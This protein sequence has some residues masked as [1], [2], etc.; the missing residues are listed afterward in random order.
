[1]WQL[2]RNLGTPNFWNPQSLSRPVMGFPYLY[3][4]PQPIACYTLYLRIHQ[5]IHVST[6][7]P[8]ATTLQFIRYIRVE[9]RHLVSIRSASKFCLLKGITQIKCAVIH[10]VADSGIIRLESTS[11]N[12]TWCCLRDC[13]QRQCLRCV[14]SVS[15]NGCPWCLPELLQTQ[16]TRSWRDRELST[17]CSH[18]MY[19]FYWQRYKWSVP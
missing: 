12:T 7:C 4:F 3:L 8:W 19:Y 10:K 1:M 18:S 9:K 16:F 14:A 2:F 13:V 11:W 17:G 5:H 15:E 6:F